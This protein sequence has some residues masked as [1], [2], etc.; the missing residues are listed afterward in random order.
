MF[1]LTLKKRQFIMH[2]T[3]QSSIVDEGR[4]FEE[5]FSAAYIQLQSI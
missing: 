2:V 5:S 1:K 4:K 3:W